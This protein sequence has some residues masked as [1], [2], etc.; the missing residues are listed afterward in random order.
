MDEILNCQIQNKR[1]DKKK[2]VHPCLG[3][4]SRMQQSDNYFSVYCV[5][6]LHLVCREK[7]KEEKW[8][9]ISNLCSRTALKKLNSL[10]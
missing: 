7:K 9:N 4:A 5:E 3:D 2:T 1:Q 10:I 6:N 8:N